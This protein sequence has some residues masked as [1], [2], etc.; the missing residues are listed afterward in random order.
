MNSFLRNFSIRQRLLGSMLVLSIL[1]IALGVWAAVAFKSSQARG[2]ALLAKQTALSAESSEL[3]SALERVQRL[4]QSVLLTANNAVEAGDHLAAWTKE[5][6]KLRALLQAN[7]SEDVRQ[8]VMAEGM[9]GFDTYAKEVAPVLQQVV[10]AKMDASAGF[11]YASRNWPELEKTRAGF[12]TWLGNTRE[13]MAAEQAEAKSHEAAQSLFRLIAVST[14]LI[15]FSALNWAIVKSIARPLDDASAAAGRIAKGDLSE[16]VPNTGRDEVSR[17][18]DRLNEMQSA[19]REVVSQVRNS[20]DSIRTA[21]DEV[22][23]GN[24]DLSQRTEHTAS[25]LQQT[26]ASMEE[27]TGTV[28]HSADSAAQA[29]QMAASATAVAQRGGQAVTQVVQTMDAINTASRKIADITGVIDGIA[30]QTN[31]LALNAA[32]E[33]ARAGE[34]GRGFAVVAGE[35]RSLAQRSAE[36]AREIKSLIGASVEQVESG[37]RQVAEAG[38]TM[39]DIVSS[40]RRVDDIIQEISTATTEQSKGIGEVGVA[41]SQL[42]QMTQQNAALVEE[43]AA[44]AESL[45][46]QARQLAEVVATFRLSSHDAPLLTH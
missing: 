9:A 4:E 17:F 34:Q 14:M 32:V 41:V 21:S 13:T 22:A 11:A 19:L 6:T 2:E 39:S 3:S 29:S 36:A 40:V 12:A 15:A 43:S 1:V 28:R 16:A 23:T 38:T 31:I 33:A 37:T 7:L 44:A 10:D 45:K 8:G 18:V 24:L 30:F 46:Q 5:T 20:A 35:V 27:L 26:A 42:D 25:N